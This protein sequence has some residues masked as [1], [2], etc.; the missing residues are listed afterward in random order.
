MMHNVPREKGK[1]PD[2]ENKGRENS[3][4]EKLKRVKAHREGKARKK[5]TL[6]RNNST[7]RGGNGEKFPLLW[8]ALGEEALSKSGKRVRRT[9]NCNRATGG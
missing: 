9:E 5:W 8:D 3:G 2:T 4:G 6:L 7:K 1:G